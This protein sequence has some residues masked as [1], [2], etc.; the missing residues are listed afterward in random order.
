[1]SRRVTLIPS[2]LAAVYCCDGCA[3]AVVRAQDGP[4]DGWN[5][6]NTI[7]AS[8]PGVRSLGRLDLCASCHMAALLREPRPAA[9][10]GFAL[11]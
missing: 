8:Q 7:R 2:G 10:E 9:A 5:T 1:M 4:P 11:A 3:A 6:R